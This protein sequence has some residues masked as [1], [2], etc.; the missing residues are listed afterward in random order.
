MNTDTSIWVVRLEC[1]HKVTTDSQEGMVRLMNAAGGVYCDPCR[2]AFTPYK[3]AVAATEHLA[4]PDA[5][6]R[7]KAKAKDA[8]PEAPLEPAV[9]HKLDNL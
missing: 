2:I 3:K 4:A 1:G 9:G 6:D 7:A 8:A 5:K